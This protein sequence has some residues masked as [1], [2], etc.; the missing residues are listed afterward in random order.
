[1]KLRVSTRMTD[2]EYRANLAGINTFFGAV[3]GFVISGIEMLDPFRFG[4]VLLLVA[5]VVISILYINAS[6]HRLAYS[7]YT[8][9]I[10]AALPFVVDSFSRDG[11]ALPPKLQPTLVVWA[12]VTIF[13]EFAPRERPSADVSAA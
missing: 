2:A 4:V 11:F 1:M 5:G 7:L 10:I 13:V 9:G 8:L 6:K 12:L 3:L